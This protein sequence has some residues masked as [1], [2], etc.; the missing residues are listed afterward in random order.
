MS[1]KVLNE[2]LSHHGGVHD[3]HFQALRFLNKQFSLRHILY[4]G[5]WIHLTPS[6]VFP[7][8]VYVDSFSKMKSMLGD[9]EL[10]AYIG[11]HS[12]KIHPY[13]SEKQR[14]NEVNRPRRK[15]FDEFCFINNYKLI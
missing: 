15:S 3:W 5:S 1:S 4:P 14:E 7:F 8:V 2:Y 6:I 12:E 10:L 13:L 9:L 11:R